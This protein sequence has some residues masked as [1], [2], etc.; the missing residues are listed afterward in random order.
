MLSSTFQRLS[1]E[2]ATTT[3]TSLS[4]KDFSVLPEH[5]SPKAARI[6]EV[7]GQLLIA[8]GA[9]GVTIA[10]VAQKAYVGKGTVYLYWASKE[11]LLLGLIGREFLTVAERLTAELNRDPDNACPARF[12][13]LALNIIDASPLVSALQAHNDS[14]LGLLTDHPLSTSIYEAL[15]P[16][17][18]LRTIVP[19]WRECGLART[20][21]NASDQILALHVLISGCSIVQT[22]PAL[23]ETTSDPIMVFAHTINAVL[24]TE[25][26]SRDQVWAAA[27][28]IKKFLSDGSAKVLELIS[29]PDGDNPPVGS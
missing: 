8:R 18:M 22:E 28:G 11:E 25:D 24:E 16:V 3:P 15:G 14:I 21:W 6:L 19:I 26:P 27:D 17:A 4:G 5:S 7:A 9:K 23:L 29:V 12:C 2:A 10:D 13:P 1:F 20:E